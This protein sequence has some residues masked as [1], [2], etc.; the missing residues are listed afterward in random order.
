MADPPTDPPT[1]D[2]D[3]P[4]RTPPMTEREG[5]AGERLRLRACGEGDL[6][7]RLSAE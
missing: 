2:E 4:A 6:W 1:G 5:P 7:F 3:L